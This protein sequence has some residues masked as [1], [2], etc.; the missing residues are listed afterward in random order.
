MQDE[1][2]PNFT[3]FR[4]CL[5]LATAFP[6]GL[7]PAALL[8]TSFG[9][10]FARQAGEEIQ[11]S[12]DGSCVSAECHVN[13]TEFSNRHAVVDDCVSCHVQS[14]EGHSFEPISDVAALCTQ[15]HSEV[16]AQPVVHVPAADDCTGCHLPHGSEAPK[17]LANSSVGELCFS[18]HDPEIVGRTYKH[19]PA[20]AGA[21]TACHDPH[22]AP[23]QN[24]V[25]APVTS[26]CEGCHVDMAEQL[27]ASNDVHPPVASDCT[28]C[29]DP[30][31]GP[32]PRMVAS[33][34]RRLCEACHDTVTNAADQAAVKHAP[35]EAP[36]GCPRCHQP[37]ASNAA[38][39][40]KQA[41]MDLCL[42]CHN[43]P[44]P[45][46]SPELANMKALLA[47]NR[48]WHGPI[49]EGSCVGCHEVHG[50]QHFRL[51][52]EP[53]PARFY[54]PFAT[55][56]YALCFECHEASAVTEQYTTSLTGFRDGDLNLHYVHVRKEHRGRTCRACH[57]VHASSQPLHIRD[58]V[59]YGSWSLPIGFQ[60]DEKGG[61]CSPGCHEPLPYQ[62]DSKQ[63]RAAR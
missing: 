16:T 19:G 39:L 7:I 62:R 37:H 42:S 22:S 52:A 54:S 35:V 32:E 29:H 59:P 44:L 48:N 40:L 24:L 17:L 4:Q 56:N 61:S 49:T 63:P 21:C 47:S 50:S 23:E 3:P 27:A 38:P 45:D 28:L 53:Y 41:E 58:S 36:D 33:K 6:L 12:P 11:I 5:R 43:R 20:A 15:C 1:R 10:G 57:E 13:I 46:T 30:H 34:G 31:S 9:S 18:C 51:L 60:R 8:L 25:R 2:A 55:E 26:L 14:S